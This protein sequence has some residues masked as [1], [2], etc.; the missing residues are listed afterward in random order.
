MRLIDHPAEENIRCLRQGATF[1]E[2]LDDPMFTEQPDTFFRGGVGGQ[3]R[4]CIDFYA[5][6]VR[7][8]DGGRINY[9]KRERDPR[10][11][12]DR[13]VAADCMR[14]LADKLET[15]HQDMARKSL[16]VLSDS[17]SADAL[18]ADWS[19]STLQ[20]E[21]QFLASHTIHHFALIVSI[22]VRL[23]WKPTAEFS[24]FGIAPSTLS[25]W[26]STDRAAG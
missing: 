24:E 8:M 9:A 2:Q 6:L 15:I 5:C 26:Q 12:T 4:H 18:D 23:G 25:H 11:E 7:D 17:H 19:G 16:E 22:L 21:L 3:F 1:I 10:V 13:A 14:Q 20:R